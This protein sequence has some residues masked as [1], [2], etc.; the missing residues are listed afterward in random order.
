MKAHKHKDV[1][2]AW[3]NGAEIQ[4]RSPSTKLWTDNDTPCW[5]GSYDYRVKPREFKEGAWYPVVSH[6]G[7]KEMALFSEGKFLVS[8][9]GLECEEHNFKWIGEALEIEWPDN[10]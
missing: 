6:G 1:I 5:I 10:G 4:H 9:N 3:A 2:I 8:E 7:Y